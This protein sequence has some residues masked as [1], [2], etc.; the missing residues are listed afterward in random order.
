MQN[1]S[2]Q[3]RHEALILFT[4]HLSNVSDITS[5]VEL[6]E[7]YTQSISFNNLSSFDLFKEVVITFIHCLND[8]LDK[9]YEYEEALVIQLIQFKLLNVSYI[10][11][12]DNLA[13][14]TLFYN[15]FKST[16]N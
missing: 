9:N 7:L 1:F 12:E 13:E 5:N 2:L 15:L 14:D 10:Y 8:I 6:Q 4:D 3:S 16:F 11:F